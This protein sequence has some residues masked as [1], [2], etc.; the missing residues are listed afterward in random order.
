MPKPDP[1]PNPSDFGAPSSDDRAREVGE[2]LLAR[3]KET[4]RRIMRRVRSAA[5]DTDLELPSLSNDPTEEAR[6]FADS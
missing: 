2:Q 1:T 4:A 3:V 6:P 5:N